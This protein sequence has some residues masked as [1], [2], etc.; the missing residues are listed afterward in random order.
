LLH[1]KQAGLGFPSLTSK[2]V[3]ALPRVVRVTSSHMLRRDEVEDG[4]IDVLSCVRSFYPK[5]SVFYVL[6]RR[7]N[8]IFSI[9]IEARNRT[10]EE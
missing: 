8:L 10:V 9:L 4:W 7:G 3:E 6:Y 5:I 2:L 1:L